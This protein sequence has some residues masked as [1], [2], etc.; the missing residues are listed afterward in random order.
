M[1]DNEHLLY[2]I[3]LFDRNC[4]TCCSGTI[5]FFVENLEDFEEN[6]LPLAA[7]NPQQVERYY[8]SKLGEIVTDFYSDDPKLNIVQSAKSKVITED[9]KTYRNKKVTLTNSYCFSADFEFDTL[10]IILRVIKYGRKYYL[11]GQYKG[12]G[13]K[14]VGEFYNRWYDKKVK[15][16]QMY[17]FGNPIADYQYRKPEL[18]V[19]YNQDAYKDYYTDDKEFFKSDTIETFVWLPIKEVKK[20]YKIKALTKQELAQLLV[21][22]IG[23]SG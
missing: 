23:E 4:A 21:D 20:D 7:R 6:W 15:Y 1:S 14:R 2:R 18:S 19:F 16:E 9:K 17:F 11:V 3:E 10:Q 13:C 8:R 22:I 5:F 12:K